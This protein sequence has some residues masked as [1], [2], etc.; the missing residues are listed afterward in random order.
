MPLL[1]GKPIERVPPPAVDSTASRPQGWQ[2]RFTD[3]LF[4]DYDKYLER[5]ALYRRTIWTC[6]ASGQS[7][8]TYEQ[9][10]LSERASY[11][12]TTGIGFSDALICEMLLFISQSRLPISQAIDALYYRFL[13]DFFLGEHLDVKYPDTQGA[14]YECVV[15]G[16]GALPHA[17]SAEMQ[18]GAQIAIERLG[19]SAPEIINMEGR[20]Q[21]LFTVR[22]FDMDGMPID[23]SD[24]TVPA[25][26]LSRSRNVFT[27][28][29]LRQFLDAHTLRGSRPGSPWII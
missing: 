27:K 24:I 22:L 2:I 20:M 4:D 12:R 14:M 23:D 10:L 26:E 7:G 8:L 18:T 28:V 6:S 1:D 25:S 13:Y 5:M 9:A 16:I 19:D 3:E 15:V 11:H 29:A 17:M 21:R